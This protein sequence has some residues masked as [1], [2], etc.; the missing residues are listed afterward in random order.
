MATACNESQARRELEGNISLPYMTNNDQHALGGCG[1]QNGSATSG[2]CGIELQWRVRIT[3]WSITL[4]MCIV[5]AI[6]NCLFLFVVCRDPEKKRKQNVLTRNLSAAHLVLLATLP[7]EHLLQY[8]SVH[9]LICQIALLPGLVALVCSCCTVM[10]MSI[11]RMRCSII[12]QVNIPPNVRLI[13]PPWGIG[14]AVTVAVAIFPLD[15]DVCFL[16]NNDEFMLIVIKSILVGMFAVTFISHLAC[17]C[18]VKKANSVGVVAGPSRY[19]PTRGVSILIP[20]SIHTA[21]HPRRIDVAEVATAGVVECATAAAIQGIQPERSQRRNTVVTRA[22]QKWRSKTFTSENGLEN[23]A[24]HRKVPACCSRWRTI[25]GGRRV[26]ALVCL[27]LLSYA[28][29]FALVWIPDGLLDDKVRHELV[30]SVALPLCAFNAALDPFICI[31]SDRKWQDKVTT[32]LM[33]K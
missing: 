5:G 30:V 7:I 4:T 33:C 28:P 20:R 6:G 25:L 17:L 9:W 29:L 14:V 2:M 11:H 23:S 19:H 13:F 24:V 18:L 8:L 16:F 15:G 1:S 31:I 27:F 21:S 12:R 10:I 32:L 26:S 3:L 22:A